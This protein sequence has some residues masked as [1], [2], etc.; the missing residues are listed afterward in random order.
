MKIM[1]PY[2][3]KAP[4][5]KALESA[6]AQAKAAGAELH[7]VMSFRITSYNVCYTKLL[8]FFLQQHQVIGAD[9]HHLGIVNQVLFRPV[10]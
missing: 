7:V 2:D 9:R 1:V 5:Q 3:G 6:A 4:S 10:Q 8:R